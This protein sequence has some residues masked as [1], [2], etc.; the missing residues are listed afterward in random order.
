MVKSLLG[1]V[2]GIFVSQ[3]AFAQEVEMNIY[4]DEHEHARTLWQ[5]VW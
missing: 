3:F 1:L 5:L 4:A 2:L